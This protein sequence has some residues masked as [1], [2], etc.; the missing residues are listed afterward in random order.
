M[1]F[2]KGLALSLLS[3][4]L[5][6]SLSVF[7]FVLTL[8]YTILNPDFAIAELNKLDIPSLIKPLIKEQIGEQLPPEAQF[9]AAAIDDTIDDAVDELEPWIREQAS[10]VIRSGYDYLLGRSQ[11]LSVAISLEPAKEILRDNAREAFFQELP[12]ELQ[13]LPRAEVERYFDE[14]YED[15]AREIPSTFEFD[16][17]SLSPDVLAGLEQAKQVVSYLQLAYW[18]LIGFMLLLI[19]GIILINRQVKPTTRGLGTTFLIYGAIEYAGI[20]VAKHFAG[21]QLAQF[22][23]PSALQTW[24]PQLLADFLAPLEMF[25]LG[26]M[27]AGVVLIIVSFAYKPPEPSF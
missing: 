6:L 14:F 25:S 20:F 13:G 11:S 2:L 16:E 8:N 17:S 4:L 26:L 10:T 21:P 19:L 5:F 7:G 3:L 9:M 23:I 18:A 24:L 15:F 12:P 1:K 27:I 22:E